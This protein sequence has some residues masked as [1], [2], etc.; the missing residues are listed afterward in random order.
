ML[1]IEVGNE[2]EKREIMENKRKLR[3]R[4]IWI[5]DDL[6]W[7]ERRA[8]WMLMQVAIR[9]EAE[10]RKVWL[11][12]GRIQIEGKWWVWDEE[13]ERLRD[14]LGKWREEGEEDERKVGSNGDKRGE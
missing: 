13:E 1:V 9:K 5:E 11:K 7:K 3:G 14:R 10:G 4:E 8:K 12:Q 2:K 6:T